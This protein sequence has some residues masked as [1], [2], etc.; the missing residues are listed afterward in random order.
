MKVNKELLMRVI[1]EEVESYFEEEGLEGDSDLY[2][3]LFPEE[4]LM[5]E[6]G[7]GTVALGVILGILAWKGLKI[8]ARLAANIL[9]VVGEVGRQKS[10]EGYRKL[11]RELG[12]EVIQSAVDM[13]DS[14]EE[15][16]ALV[17]E[18]H[19]LVQQV[20][21]IK[22]QRGLEYQQIRARRKEVSKEL[23]LR[24]NDKL[25]EILNAQKPNTMHRFRKYSGVS[26]EDPR[27]LFR[28]IKDYAR[29]ER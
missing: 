4:D 15:L 24:V 19:V 25:R 2:D 3:E 12:S 18:Y 28:H 22:G 13:I 20:E 8:T 7:V 11:A 16:T 21:D 6:M 27:Q 29:R 1:K 9:D 17:T 26:G 10:K 14:D 5:E 23:S